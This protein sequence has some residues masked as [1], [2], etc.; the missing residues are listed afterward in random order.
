MGMQLIKQPDNKFGLFDHYNDRIFLIDATD[1]EL[2]EVWKTRA[3]LRA[4]A[5][6][7]QWLKEV[8]TGKYR[9][10]EKPI[11][12]KK[13]LSMHTFDMKQDFDKMLKSIK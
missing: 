9:L 8:K 13:A 6:M 5:E 11:S 4:E 7:R 12:L 3:A 10:H 1:E 2:V